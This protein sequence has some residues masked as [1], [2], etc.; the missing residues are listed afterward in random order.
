MLSIYSLQVGCDTGRWDQ[1]GLRYMLVVAM[2]ST[3]H[4]VAVVVEVLVDKFTT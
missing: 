2:A 1:F 3:V 4:S